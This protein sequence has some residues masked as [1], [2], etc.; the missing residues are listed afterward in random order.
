M[1][2]R[3]VFDCPDKEKLIDK[4]LDAATKAGGGIVGNYSRCAI[5]TRGYGTWKSG[6]GAHPNIGKVGKVSNVSSVKVE[7]PCARGKIKAVCKALRK[8]HPYEEPTIYIMK[9]NSG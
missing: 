9:V 1:E 7:M 3:I 2:Y 8:A 5:I 4:L 6:K